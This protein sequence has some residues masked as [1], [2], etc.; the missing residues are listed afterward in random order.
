[1]GPFPEDGAAS[2]AQYFT[3]GV[4]RGACDLVDFPT[5]YSL[6]NRGDYRRCVCETW[7]PDQDQTGC[8]KGNAGQPKEQDSKDRKADEKRESTK[9]HREDLSQEDDHD[10]QD[11]EEHHHSDPLDGGDHDEETTK[12]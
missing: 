2:H 3:K 11:V 1:M 12:P 4:K 7:Y 5:A 6:Y 9:T 10:T 8:I